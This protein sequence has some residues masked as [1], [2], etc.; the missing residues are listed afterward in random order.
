MGA[1]VVGILPLCHLNFLYDE[2][3]KK[4]CLKASVVYVTTGRHLSPMTSRLF[5]GSYLNTLMTPMDH[6]LALLLVCACLTACQVGVAR[7]TGPHSS[8]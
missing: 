7:K 2:T 1:A 6:C 5:L 8:G 3:P 4:E